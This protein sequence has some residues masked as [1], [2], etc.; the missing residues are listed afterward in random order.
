MS[1]PPQLMQAMMA[2]QGGGASAAPGAAPGAT[3]GMGTPPRPG[4]APGAPMAAGMTTPQAQQ[5]RQAMGHVQVQ[6]A[7]QVLEHALPMLGS[8][9]KE[10]AAVIRSLDSLSKT[11]GNKDNGDLVPAQLVSMIQQMPQMGGGSPMQRQLLAQ[12]QHGGPPQPGAAP[13][14]PGAAS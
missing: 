13:P 6:I 8:G 5:G 10:G 2:R 12:L 7:M 4:G 11:F 9:S 3:P 14:P 1:V